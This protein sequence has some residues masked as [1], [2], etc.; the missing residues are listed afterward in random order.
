MRNSSKSLR[1]PPRRSTGDFYLLQSL[2]EDDRDSNAIFFN[3]RLIRVT[4]SLMFAANLY[5]ALGVPGDKAEH[6]RNA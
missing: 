3:S 2:F 5:E 1:H 6:T 4:E